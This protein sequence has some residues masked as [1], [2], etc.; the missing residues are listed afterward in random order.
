MNVCMCER[1]TKSTRAQKRE[2]DWFVCVC[3]RARVC[4]CFVPACEI[5]K[6]HRGKRNLFSDAFLVRFDPEV[7]VLLHVRV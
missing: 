5:S 3:A 2:R 7:V 4:V 6:R 1:E